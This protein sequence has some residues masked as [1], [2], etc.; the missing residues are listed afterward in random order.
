MQR[1][2]TAPFPEVYL[3][4]LKPSTNY[5]IYVSA[6][7]PDD[8]IMKSLATTF[9]TADKPDNASKNCFIHVD[10]KRKSICK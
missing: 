10:K 1:V 5:T 8:R 4:G 2:D 7:F 6:V 3:T 9:V